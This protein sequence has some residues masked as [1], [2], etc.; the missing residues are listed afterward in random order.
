MI[1]NNVSTNNSVVVV[2]PVQYQHQDVHGNNNTTSS[3]SNTANAVTN[4]AEIL[5][6]YDI[7]FLADIFV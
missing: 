2:K 4:V 6:D 7:E 3:S 1:G 5:P